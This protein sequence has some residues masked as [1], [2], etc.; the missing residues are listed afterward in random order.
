MTAIHTASF[1][2]LD[3]RT[4]YLLWQLRQRVFVVEQK[5]FYLDLDGRDLEPETRHLWIEEDGLPVA[6]LRVLTERATDQPARAESAPES[7]TGHADGQEELR[8]GRVLV[9]EGH[10]GRGLAE[11]LMK[12]AIKVVDGRP[13]RLDAQS[14]LV[15]WYR[16]LGFEPSGE[17]FLEDGIPHVPMTQSSRSL[18]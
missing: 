1:A 18:A 13:C 6:Y 9:A 16:R 3:A 2:D 5:C 4:G 8:I 14:Y 15:D 17:E 11:R 12:A 7:A 10:R